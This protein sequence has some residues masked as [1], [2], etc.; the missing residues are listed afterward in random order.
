MGA[1]DVLR[2]AHDFCVNL[3][4]AKH[5]YHRANKS[6]CHMASIHNR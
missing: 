2:P 4:G 3:F 5:Q 1:M 6:H